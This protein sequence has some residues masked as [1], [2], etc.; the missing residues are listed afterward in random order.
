MLNLNMSPAW[1][2]I[3]NEVTNKIIPQRFQIPAGGGGN[4]AG[5]GGDNKGGGASVNN[6]SLKNE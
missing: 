1:S 3:Q 4:K 2:R 6:D 5:S